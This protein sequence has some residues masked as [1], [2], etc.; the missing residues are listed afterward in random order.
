MS[1][2][3]T[4]EV[5]EGPLL[6]EM[7]DEVIGVLNQTSDE[8]PCMLELGWLVVGNHAFVEQLVELPSVPAPF[9][10]VSEQCEFPIRE[11][12]SKRHIVFVRL[13]Y[14]IISRTHRS[15]ITRPCRSDVVVERL[16]R[17]SLAASYEPSRIIGFP[18]AER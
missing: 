17:S 14:V 5:K 16:S 11:P 10:S 7:R 4:A 12:N 18:R 13:V 3:K 15:A 1:A 2:A 6:A 9:W 8:F